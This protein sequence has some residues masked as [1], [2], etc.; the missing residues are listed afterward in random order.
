M[1][2]KAG[3]TAQA[4]TIFTDQAWHQGH[5]MTHKAAVKRNALQCN[6]AKQHSIGVMEKEQLTLLA[7]KQAAPSIFTLSSLAI[8]TQAARQRAMNVRA[9]ARRQQ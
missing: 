6:Y 3:F 7:I 1:A 2:F 8:R 9:A 5:A 4:P